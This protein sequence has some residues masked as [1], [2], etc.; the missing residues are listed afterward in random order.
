M[1]LSDSVNLLYSTYPRKAP[2]YLGRRDNPLAGKFPNMNLA[3]Q[4]GAPHHLSQLSNGMGESL[5]SYRYNRVAGSGS[6]VYIVDTGLRQPNHNAPKG[7]LSRS[8][9]YNGGSNNHRVPTE[10][11]VT[12]NDLYSDHE[13]GSLIAAL[14][15]NNNIG[16][17]RKAKLVSIKVTEGRDTMFTTLGLLDG[18][19]WAIDDIVRQKRQQ[20]AVITISLGK[21]IC[22]L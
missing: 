16:I 12:G 3:T 1:T 9:L 11:S 7:D 15:V 21:Y 22:G 4:N 8:G 20:T 10:H 6:F 5:T 19:I 17:A 18:I 13:H 14:A 2:K